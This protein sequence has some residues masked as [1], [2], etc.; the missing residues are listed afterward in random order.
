VRRTPGHAARSAAVTLCLAL[1]ATTGCTVTNDNVGG[2]DDTAATER[3]GGSEHVDQADAAT[4][5]SAAAVASFGTETV[6]FEATMGEVMSMSG[7]V[8]P[9]EEAGR[10]TMTSGLMGTDMEMEMIFIGDSMWLS[11]PSITAMLGVQEPWIL[12]EMSSLDNDSVFGIRPGESDVVGVTEM[13]ESLGEVERVDDRTYRGTIYVTGL[14]GDGAIDDDVLALADEDLEFT[15]VLDAQGRLSEMTIQMPTLPMIGDV[16]LHTRF[17]DYGVPL[18]ISPP[19]DDQVG[20]M[21]PG[22]LG[23]LQSM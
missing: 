4:Q 8:D 13:L 9:T 7:E 14:S 1:L 3:T 15:A 22:L 18:Q 12:V 10:I 6:K 23:M 2:A 16:T 19:P 11:I 17:F 21:V 5:L 20:E